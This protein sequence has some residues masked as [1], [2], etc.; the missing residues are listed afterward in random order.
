[1]ARF[2]LFYLE[3]FPLLGEDIKEN[4]L[5]R[6][7][8]KGLKDKGYRLVLATNSLFPIEALRETFTLG[9]CRSR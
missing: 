8:V 2:D 3:K 7:L 6:K 4:H 1:M 9:Q 5:S